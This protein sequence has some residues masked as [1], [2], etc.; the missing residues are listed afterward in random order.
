MNAFFHLYCSRHYSMK[1]YYLK[2]GVHGMHMVFWSTECARRKDFHTEE[3]GMRTCCSYKWKS[4]Q[5]IFKCTL[6]KVLTWSFHF[7]LA[8]ILANFR[9]KSLDQTGGWS[10]MSAACDMWNMCNSGS[11]QSSHIKKRLM[12]VQQR[13]AVSHSSEC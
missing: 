13:T 2:P 4:G 3:A 9:N 11:L 5:F 12:S 7:L 6:Y 1:Q 10:F 8:V